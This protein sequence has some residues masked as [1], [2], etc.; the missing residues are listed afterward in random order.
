MA[1]QA[2]VGLVPECLPEPPATK[3]TIENADR[4]IEKIIPQLSAQYHWLE[5]VDRQQLADLFNE[6]AD[7]R[8]TY[9]KEHDKPP[10]DG[11]IYR[12]YRLALE[13]AEDEAHDELYEKVVLLEALMDGNIVKG[14]LPSL[15]TYISR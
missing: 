8:D 15:D 3:I 13:Q 6:I 9:A 1:R 7:F 11:R 12:Q 14:S 5:R 4:L 2:F 10:S